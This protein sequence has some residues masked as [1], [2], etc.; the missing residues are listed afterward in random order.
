[1][2]LQ[3]YYINTAIILLGAYL[4]GAF[5]T[6]FIAGKIRG[7]DV[8]K[9]GSHNVGGMNTFS[10][11]GKIAGVFV[12]LADFG[13][14]TLVAFLAKRFSNSHSLIPLLAIVAAVI[15][16][17]WMVYIGFKGG[18]GLST[19][20]GGLLFL[21]PLSFFFLYLWFVPAAIILVKDTYLATSIALFFFSFFLW[22]REGSYN[23][24]IFGILISIVYSIKSYSLIK[25]Y[26]TEERRDVPPI[27]RKIFKP[28]F[29][30]V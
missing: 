17:N 4:T 12:I 11:V 15:G 1:M 9:T 28:F 25:T 16:H 13:K 27:L 24:L 19:F 20:L 3:N 18:K 7:I 14:G 21:S 23:W 26:F 10:S 30:N 5:P 22:Y 2:L 8:R 29:K 6:A